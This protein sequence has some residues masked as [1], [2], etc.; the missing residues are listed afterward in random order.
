MTDGSVSETG[1]TPAA[2][3]AAAKA[4]HKMTR[5]ESAEVDRNTW[6]AYQ[7]AKRNAEV[8][9][10]EADKFEAR[11]REQARDAQILTVRGIRVATRIITPVTGASFTKDYYR[12]TPGESS[13]DED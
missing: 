13:T 5:G 3:L 2:A 1:L 12:R 9:Q 6:L 11:L 4:R 7:G 10:A 8:Y